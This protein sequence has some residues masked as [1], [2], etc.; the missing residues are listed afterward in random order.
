MARISNSP[1]VASNVLAGAALAGM[2]E[3]RPQIALLIVAMVAFYTAGMLFNDYCDYG[4]DLVHRPDRPLVQGVVSRQAALI[5]T[6]ALFGIGEALLL[7][8]GIAPVIGGLLL[9]G[10]IVLYD[11]WHKSNPLSPL[12]MAACRLM[13]YVIA[14]VAFAWPP[15]LTL[16]LGGAALV[17]YL[18]GVTAI[19]KRGAPG[20]VVAPL[21]AGIS[22][23]D[24]IVLAVMQA[25]LPWI[26]MAV[27]CFGLTLF[28]QRYVEGT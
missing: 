1:T 8:L 23:L 16:A 24:A 17:L 3:P 9:I 12:V 28:F 21:L 14:F 4:W 25:P 10:C 13:V 11:T 19:A 22:I 6:L 7:P 15:N 2:V 27:L 20:R 26:G 18:V 5:G